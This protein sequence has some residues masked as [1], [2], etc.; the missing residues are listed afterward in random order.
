MGALQEQLLPCMRLSTTVELCEE[1]GIT[2][3]M[4]ESVLASIFKSKL[5]VEMSKEVT[6]EMCKWIFLIVHL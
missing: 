2:A 6:E 5:N 4:H 3:A 1:H